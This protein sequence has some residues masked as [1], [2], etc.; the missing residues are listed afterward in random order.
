VEVNGFIKTEP[1]RITPDIQY[2]V[3][4]VLPNDVMM[5]NLGVD[6]AIFPEMK[7]GYIRCLAFSMSFAFLMFNFLVSALLRHCFTRKAKALLSFS[8]L[9][10]FST[11]SSPPIISLRRFAS[12][13]VA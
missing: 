4:S 8:L 3:L 12:T 13:P 11:P 2:T 9:I 5:D 6:K 10:R 1:N 7:Y